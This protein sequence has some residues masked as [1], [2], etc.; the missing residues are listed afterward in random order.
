MNTSLN[1]LPQE[2]K[3][4]FNLMFMSDIIFDFVH[5][6][7]DLQVDSDETMYTQFLNGKILLPFPILSKF[8]M[9]IFRYLFLHL[10]PRYNNH[11]R[12]ALLYII[13]ERC[14]RN[15]QDLE[16]IGSTSFFNKL[17]FEKDP[18]VSFLASLFLIELLQTG[19]PEEFSRLVNNLLDKAVANNDEKLIYNP[20]LQIK[21]ILEMKST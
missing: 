21:A 1:V 4:E 10:P 17:L 6:R 13:I 18:L 3:N 5:I 14:K 7:T 20:Y 16:M 11:I 19:K 2:K 15:K 8:N 12:P 9:A